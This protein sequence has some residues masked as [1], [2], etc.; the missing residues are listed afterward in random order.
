MKKTFLSILILAT[1]T[2]TA[3][4]QNKSEV[5]LS[6]GVGLSS[7]NYDFEQSGDV[8]S[9]IAPSFA[10]GY[11]Y[12]LNTNWGVVSGLEF[13]TYKAE[14]SSQ[15]VKAQYAE[16]DNYNDNFE[17]RLSLQGIKEKQKGSY[18][19]I[20]IMAQFMPGSGDKFYA[21][22][23]FKI[24]LPLKGKYESSYTKLIAKGYYPDIDAEYTDIDF[25][26]FG[27]FSGNSSKGDIDFKVAFIASAEVGMKWRLTNSLNLYT[28]G[29]IDY[30][31]NN[32]VKNYGQIIDYDKNNPIAII[33]QNS[34]IA[35]NHIT[36]E[37]T[38]PFVDKVVPFSLGMKIKLGFSL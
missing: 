31:L 13:A 2:L 7:L 33:E 19:N 1:A 30:G 36:G 38:K 26:G 23:G 21:N 28:G 3:I 10:I 34:L 22:L 32:I 18:L 29:Y 14:V 17:W 8:K 27:E 25:R 6:F 15:E 9:K 35:S 12:K 37:D 16:Q 24:G 20:P 4:A 11:T 5:S